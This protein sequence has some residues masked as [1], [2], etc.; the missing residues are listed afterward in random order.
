MFLTIM[1]YRLVTIVGR[2]AIFDG[3]RVKEAAIIN[4]KLAS[5]QM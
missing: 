4:N 3:L 5:A 1:F 2:I